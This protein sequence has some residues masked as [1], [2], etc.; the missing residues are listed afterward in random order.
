MPMDVYDHAE[1]STTQFAPV[2]ALAAYYQAQ[3]VL[4]PLARVVPTVR[5]RKYTLAN[6]L[7]QVLLSILT[8]CEYLSLTNTI[9]R[10]EHALAQVYSI[11]QFAAASTLSRTLDRLSQ[12][13]LE[14]LERAV[15]AIS[16]R[17][18][19]TLQHDWRG[20]LYLDFDLS[21]LPCGTQAQGSSKGYFSEKK[22]HRT[23]I[24]TGE[25]NQPSRNFVVRALSGQSA[26]DA[27]SATCRQ[28]RRNCVRVSAPATTTDGLSA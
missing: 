23:P 11:E 2:G 12:T 5:K 27:L 15:R 26:D 21:G 8:G 17:C 4:E 20:F 3:Q 16:R 9:L 22:H 13:N 25:C 28:G 10:P 6:Q 14:Q 19:R 18:S 7:T 1:H 24:G